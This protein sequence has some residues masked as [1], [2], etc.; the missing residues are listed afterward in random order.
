MVATQ[1]DSLPN[2]GDLKV[3]VREMPGQTVVELSGELDLATVATLREALVVL[4]L[5]SGLDMEVDLSGLSFLGSTGVGLIVT[6]CK[7]VRASGGTFSATCDHNL[8]RRVLEVSGLLDFLELHDGEEPH[9]N[10][11]GAS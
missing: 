9:P 6:A 10:Q 2:P 1:V 7:R 8:A 4:D 11:R 5:D 3:A